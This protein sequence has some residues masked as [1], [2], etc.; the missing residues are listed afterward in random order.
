MIF[1]APIFR[2]LCSANFGSEC[3]LRVKL[4]NPQKEQKFSALPR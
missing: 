4:G 3:L 1:V 2:K